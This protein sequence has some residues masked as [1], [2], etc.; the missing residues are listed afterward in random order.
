MKWNEIKI[1]DLVGAGL[2]TCRL[3]DSS[4][5]NA[6]LI[7]L[8][9]EFNILNTNFIIVILQNSHL[10]R[11]HIVCSKCT[12][13]GWRIAPENAPIMDGELPLKNWFSN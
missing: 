4:F 5:L 6:K 11:G 8:N 2:S 1:V 9:A 3:Q 12:D 10:E 7:I 13:N